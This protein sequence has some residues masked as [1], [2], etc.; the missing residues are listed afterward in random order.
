MPL[1]VIIG[2]ILTGLGAL[3]SRLVFTR[4]GQWVIALLASLGIALSTQTLVMG[5]ITNYA[6]Q[7]FAGLPGNIAEWVGFLNIDKYVS[8]VI[9][10]Y[11]GAAIKNVIL[12]KV[13]G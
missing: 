11:A 1:P 7:G 6:A 8:I 3:L 5:P 2:P 4:A 10:A 12:R 13:T 9:S